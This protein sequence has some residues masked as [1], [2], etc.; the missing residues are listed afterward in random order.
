MVRRSLDVRLA[1]QSVDAAAGNADVPQQELND[2]HG[3]DILHARPC[4][5]SSPERRDRS[6][7]VLDSRRGVHF[8]DRLE[9]LHRG[10][11]DGRDLFE[12]VSGVMCLQHLQDTPRILKGRVLF[13]DALVIKF[14]GPG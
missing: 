11:G 14:Y 7:F 5:A 9:V 3:P 4:A 10:T 12:I 8:I 1:A 13:R 2:G 6:G